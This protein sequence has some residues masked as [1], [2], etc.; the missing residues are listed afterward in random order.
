[1]WYT[2]TLYFMVK[3]TQWIYAN[4]TDAAKNRNIRKEISQTDKRS[5]QN[6]PIL[7]NEIS[8][9]GT[10]AQAGI[11]PLRSTYCIT[12]TKQTPYYE[13][14][15]TEVAALTRAGTITVEE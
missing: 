8:V 10:Y 2:T 14:T 15:A 1:M 6:L 4:A 5:F 12:M 11:D 9:L 3:N 7:R 13:L